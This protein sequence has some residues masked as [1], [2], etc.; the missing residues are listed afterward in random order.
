MSPLFLIWEVLC[1]ALLYSVF[2]RLVHTTVS[3]RI[4]VRFA[5]FF[6]GLAALVGIGAPLYG[7]EPDPVSILITAACLL[8]QLVAAHFWRGGVPR[9]FQKG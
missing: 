8:M 6:L 3:T 2:C 4:S 1:C 5:I 9:N 7:W